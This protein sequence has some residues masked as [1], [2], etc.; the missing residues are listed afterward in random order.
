[1]LSTGAGALLLQAN[2]NAKFE[3]ILDTLE[4][5]AHQPTLFFTDA[6][7]ICSFPANYPNN[8]YGFG[9]IDAQKAVE[10][11]KGQQRA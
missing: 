10:S 7:K 6:A 3:D 1:M 4:K 11:I 8:A 9:R 2:P 5:T